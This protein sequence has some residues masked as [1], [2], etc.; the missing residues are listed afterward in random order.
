M[1]AVVQLQE[2]ELKKDADINCVLRMMTIVLSEILIPVLL[3]TQKQ[4]FSK[5]G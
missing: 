2:K 4:I 1:L 3:K 5:D